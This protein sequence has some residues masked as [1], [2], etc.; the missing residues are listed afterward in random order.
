MNILEKIVNKIKVDL[1]ERKKTLSI[2]TLKKNSGLDI[3]SPSLYD[4]LNNDYL[5]LIAEIKDTSPSKGKLIKDNDVLSL[6]KNYLNADVNAISV[7]TEKNF[8]NGALNNIN[9]IK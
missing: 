2:E 1:V 9:N 5:S 8:F 7:V 4:S 6:A 3:N